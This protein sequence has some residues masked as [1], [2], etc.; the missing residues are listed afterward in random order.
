MSDVF[1]SDTRATAA[2]AQAVAAIVDHLSVR[3]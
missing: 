2:Q 3:P 1:I